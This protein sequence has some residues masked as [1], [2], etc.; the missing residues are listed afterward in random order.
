MFEHLRASAP[1]P[2]MWDCF[3]V[4]ASLAEQQQQALQQ[5]AAAAA[6]AARAMTQAAGGDL[7]AD[8]SSAYTAVMQQ[9][10]AAI[11]LPPKLD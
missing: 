2:V 9:A 3:A 6:M 5:Q 1:Y 4:V 11:A 7:S 10:G 8:L